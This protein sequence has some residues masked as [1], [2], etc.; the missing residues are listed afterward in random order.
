M[1][2]KPWMA[3]KTIVSWVNDIVGVLSCPPR[4]SSSPQCVPPRLEPPVVCPGFELDN[5]FL[6]TPC[7]AGA[8]R[9][10]KGVSTL[11]SSQE[12]RAAVVP[13]INRG[14]TAGFVLPSVYTKFRL[15]WMLLEGKG[16][17]DFLGEATHRRHVL[18]CP[19]APCR[20]AV[21]RPASNRSRYV[22]VLDSTG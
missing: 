17:G 3:R 9:G 4:P 15:L 8:Y 19:A 18:P 12:R 6:N 13:R 10:K 7:M 21:R 2:W 14:S 22:Q 1:P 16:D 5:Q 20:S 11:V